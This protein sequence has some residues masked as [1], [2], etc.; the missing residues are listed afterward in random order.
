[1]ATHSSV[2]AWRLPRDRG[3]WWAIVHG[4]PELDVTEHLSRA[5]CVNW[6][7][8]KLGGKGHGEISPEIS[9][10][11]AATLVFRISGNN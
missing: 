11:K 5:L 7:R 6:G 9:G 3:A 10:M 1:M 8:N 2:L 4:V